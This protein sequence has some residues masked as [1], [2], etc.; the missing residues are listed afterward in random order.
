MSNK[1]NQIIDLAARYQYDQA[2]AHQVECLA[3]T[4]FLELE[5]IHKLDREDRN[6][7]PGL[8]RNHANARGTDGDDGDCALQ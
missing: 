4:L 1:R 3:G 8:G 5:V 7:G 6:V 2:H